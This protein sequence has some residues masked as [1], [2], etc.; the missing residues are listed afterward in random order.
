MLNDLHKYYH[1]RDF[2]MRMRNAAIQ[3]V[4]KR[5]LFYGKTQIFV[6]LS[7]LISLCFQYSAWLIG[8]CALYHKNPC[9]MPQFYVVRT[10]VDLTNPTPLCFKDQ[11]SR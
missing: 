2:L 8:S 10:S 3:K 9:A 7:L 4:H 11:C 5:S 1:P 6:G